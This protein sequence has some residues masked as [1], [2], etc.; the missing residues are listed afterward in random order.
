MR[1]YGWQV[2]GRYCVAA[3]VVRRRCRPSNRQ[4][5]GTVARPQIQT[6]SLLVLV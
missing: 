2:L 1:V 5:S 3:I 6:M 4:P